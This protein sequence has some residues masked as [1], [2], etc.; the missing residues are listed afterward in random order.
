MQILAELKTRAQEVRLKYIQKGNPNQRRQMGNVAVARLILSSGDIYQLEATS[1]TNPMNRPVDNPKALTSKDGKPY[2]GP[3]KHFSVYRD[4]DH[5]E[6]PLNNTHAEYKLF[7][8]F[9]D[10]LEVAELGRDITGT[11]YLYTEREMCTGCE[12]VSE[13][14]QEYFK[15][16]YQDITVYVSWTRPHRRSR[17]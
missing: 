15:N 2:T 17:S 9:V 13:A 11:F 3:K 1:K 12:Q 6:K 10:I 14:F 8:A 7:N 5:P 16:Q 4:Q